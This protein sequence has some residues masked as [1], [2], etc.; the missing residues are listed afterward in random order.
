[1]VG[2]TGPVLPAVIWANLSV[3]PWSGFSLQDGFSVRLV[4]PKVPACDVVRLTT[5]TGLPLAPDSK[6]TFAIWGVNPDGTEDLLQNTPGAWP[7]YGG[8][9]A[10][11]YKKYRMEFKGV[12]KSDTLHLGT[13]TSEATENFE[14]VT[15][16]R[17]EGTY[18]SS[19]SLG[20]GTGMTLIRGNVIGA[21]PSSPIIATGGLSYDQG[22][23][24][25]V[26]GQGVPI[27]SGSYE[28]DW[29][30]PM[31]SDRLTKIN[32]NSRLR[33]AYTGSE[34]F[35]GRFS[36]RITVQNPQTFV[37]VPLDKDATSPAELD[38]M[39]FGQLFPAAFQNNEE[40]DLI[41]WAKIEFRFPV[42]EEGGFAFAISSFSILP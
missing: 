19:Y 14:T 30:M 39:T 31:E 40:Y 5:D 18:S 4:E 27:Y 8:G 12:V 15:W 41:D 36:L 6:E 33:L 20:L 16:V 35:H 2:V 37:D 26:N 9:A 7:A 38:N 28:V 13:N 22:V 32:Q 17:D 11:P 24:S 23:G 3:E 1:M 21:T 10:K 34:L 29:S 42:C 25:C